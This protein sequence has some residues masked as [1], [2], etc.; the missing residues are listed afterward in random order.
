MLTIIGTEYN[1]AHDAMEIYVSGCTRACPGCHNPEAQEFGKGKSSRLWLSENRYK[2]LTGTFRR[3]WILGGDLLCQPEHEAREFMYDLRKV[4][5]SMEFWLWTGA[6]R[7]ADVPVILLQF[8]D[9]IK[10]GAYK[11]DLPV[12]SVEYKD[13]AQSLVLA[14]A[15]QCLHDLRSM[16]ST[17]G[18][19]ETLC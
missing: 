8:F 10:T 5:P 15:N 7:L 16:A 6:E 18:G 3:V 19:E 13:G 1:A 9:I 12:R 17:A 4:A 2:F 14:T 11:K